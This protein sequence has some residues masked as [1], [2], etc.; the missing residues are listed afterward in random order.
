MLLC[1]GIFRES[2]RELTSKTPL[3]ISVSMTLFLCIALGIL[4]RMF[5]YAPYRSG[6]FHFVPAA[7]DNVGQYFLYRALIRCSQKN[8]TPQ[9]I[10]VVTQV[11]FSHGPARNR[12]DPSRCCEITC[13]KTRPPR[14]SGTFFVARLRPDSPLL[15]TTCSSSPCWR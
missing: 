9:Q 1:T 2:S 15:Q 5:F 6:D 7:D 10:P 3:E 11:A 4:A 8:M 13:D 14:S 12:A